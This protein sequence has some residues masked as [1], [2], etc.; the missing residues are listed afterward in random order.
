MLIFFGCDIQKNNTV[1]REPVNDNVVRQY[2]PDKSLKVEVPYE[3][4]KKHGIAR[5][6]Y[7]GG[8]IR[9]ETTYKE[10]IIHGISKFYFENG[11]VYR[12]TPYVNGD[13][14]GV[15]EKFRE[16]GTKAAEIKY[17]EGMPCEGLKEFYLD[18]REKENFPSLKFREIDEILTAQRVAVEVNLSEK[19]RK[20][21][22]YRGRLND[23]GC[24][25]ESKAIK[26]GD[27]LEQNIR[28]YFPL[29]PGSFRMEEIHIVVKIV[30]TQN[31]PYILYGKYNLAVENRHQ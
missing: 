16:N 28:I 22:F 7:R 8:K 23:Q 1:E 26:V 25:D 24:L 18:G 29:P 14:H 9:V 2:W 31:N 20:V 5:T 13:I 21:E 12:Q 11:R 30:T 17:F 10:G 15:V 27:G 4:K 3:N 19:V 6:Y